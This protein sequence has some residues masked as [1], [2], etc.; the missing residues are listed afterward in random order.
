MRRSTLVALGALAALG[1]ATGRQRLRASRRSAGDAALADAG[2]PTCCAA[3]AAECPA[4]GAPCCSAVLNVAGCA[5]ARTRGECERLHLASPMTQ[6][7]SVCAWLGGR[8]AVGGVADCADPRVGAASYYGEAQG[9]ASNCGSEAGAACPGLEKAYRA[10]AVAHAAATR[11]A[12]PPEGMR[13]ARLLVIRDHW[14]NVG[15]GFMPSHV[16]AVMLFAISTGM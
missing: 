7:R 5:A 15:M 10:Y 8:C 13:S 4:G 11:S 14:K 1:D 6:G 3:L 12:S 9:F 2:P 16:A